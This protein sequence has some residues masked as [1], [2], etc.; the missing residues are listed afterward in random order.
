MKRK[1]IKTKICHVCGKE[2]VPQ[3]NRYTQRICDTC[4]DRLSKEWAVW[5]EAR[6]PQRQH[7][8]ICGEPIPP[9]PEGKSW[10]W[11][12]CCSDAH[13]SLMN[14]V[15]QAYKDRIAA[16]TPIKARVNGLDAD[17]AAAREAGMSY[18]LYM[19]AKR[20]RQG[21]IRHD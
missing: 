7:C 14:S 12:G 11:K 20:K 16:Q 10:M 8:M 6:Y 2:F 9:R 19:A 15:R 1:R 3:G 5:K 21:G 4:L 17:I 13:Q 18:G